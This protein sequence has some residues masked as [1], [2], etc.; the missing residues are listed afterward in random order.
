MSGTA[1]RTRVNVVFGTG[2]LRVNPSLPLRIDMSSAFG[3]VEAPDGRSVSFGDSV[4]TSP[5]Y[6]DG[7]PAL[8]VH[9]T[10]VFGRLVIAK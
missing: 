4:Y 7:A 5:A 8:M 6:R 9:A 1:I 3:T 10:S 2:V